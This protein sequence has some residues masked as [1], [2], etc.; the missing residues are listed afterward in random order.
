[1]N[2]LLF[3]YFPFTFLI[4]RCV[5]YFESV[6]DFWIAMTFE[7]G[8][9][10]ESKYVHSHVQRLSNCHFNKKKRENVLHLSFF[11]SC[12]N[13]KRIFY[14]FL[15]QQFI[16]VI[17]ITCGLSENEWTIFHCIIILEFAPNSNKYE[18]KHIK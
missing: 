2:T 7:D 10:V 1:M 5:E 4:F 9:L 15:L 3:F 18:H 6:Y 8:C 17:I 16:D 12:L 14:L 11:P 13:I